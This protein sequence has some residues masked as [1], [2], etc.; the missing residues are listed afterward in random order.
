MGLTD[1][2]DESVLSLLLN[3]LALQECRD[4]V[5]P[6]ELVANKSVLPLDSFR[7]LEKPPA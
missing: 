2:L 1:I 6:E 7:N 5:S 3:C 4:G